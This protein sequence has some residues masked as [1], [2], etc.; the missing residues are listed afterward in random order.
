MEA[1]QVSVDRRMDEQNVVYTYDGILFSLKRKEIL[2]YA[3]RWMNLEDIMLSEIRQ[4]Q[5][6]KYYMIHLYEV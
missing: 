4:S 5:I 3:T 6:D 1:T 2:Q